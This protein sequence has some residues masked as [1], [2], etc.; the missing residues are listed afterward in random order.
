MPAP[1]ASAPAVLAG[2]VTT[3]TAFRLSPVSSSSNTPSNCAAVNFSAVSSVV[4]T[5][6]ALAS[7]ASF[8]AFTVTFA[9]AAADSASD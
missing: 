9:L 7:G 5:S 4:L 6:S 3:R 2:R 1:S 8:T